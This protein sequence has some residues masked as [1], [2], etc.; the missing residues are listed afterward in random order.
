M[1][2]SR[3][4]KPNLA[5]G[6]A[7]EAALARR[8][9]VVAAWFDHMGNP[10]EGKRLLELA[11][12]GLTR[13]ELAA[14]LGSANHVEAGIRAVVQSLSEFVDSGDYGT[15]LAV[16]ALQTT[17]SSYPAFA[18]VVRP[19]PR[20]GIAGLLLEL[21]ERAEDDTYNQTREQ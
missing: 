18:E 6:E 17:L 11:Q 20:P 5:W 16:H 9:T 7:L 4:I 15:Q 8:E 19:G 2:T 14:R 12:H 21:L 1:T 3:Q 13:E 10:G